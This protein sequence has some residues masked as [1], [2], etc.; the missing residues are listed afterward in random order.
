MHAQFSGKSPSIRFDS[1]GRLH[2]AYIDSDRVA[3]RTLGSGLSTSKAISPAA[4]KPE[5]YG[6]VGPAFALLPSGEQLVVYS[7]SV[8]GGQWSS[9]LRLQ[10]SHD[11]GATWSAPQLLHD[12]RRIT[13]HSF[14]DVAVSRAGDA[15]FSWLDDRSGHQGVHTAVLRRD[16]L[17]RNASADDFTCECCRTTLLAA[18]D[19]ALW[20][21]YRDHA[22]GDVRNMAYAISRDGGATFRRQGDI[23]DDHWSVNGC[24][25]SGP[26]LTQA[27]NGAI[28]A[29]WFNGKTTSIE[30][31]ASTAGR[32]SA[33]Q[34]LASP[35]PAFPVVNHPEIGTFPDGRLVVFYEANT[36]NGSRTLAMRIGDAQ[37]HKW[38]PAVTIATDATGPRFTRSGEHVALAFTHV[39]GNKPSVVIE[40]WRDLVASQKESQQ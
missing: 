16:A 25:D 20:L 29:T 26:R 10:R 34:I 39:E 38:T 4:D 17:S 23:A 35:S 6:E 36:A 1:K 5:A 2:I 8:A 18:A 37:G 33:P 30:A 24:P 22:D 27:R 11:G 9:E 21:A 19:G 32:F 14:A 12:D 3:I 40:D 31:A 15:V 7:V 13:S 28:W